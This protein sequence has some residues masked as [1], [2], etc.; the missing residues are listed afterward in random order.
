MQPDSVSIISSIRNRGLYADMKCHSTY[1]NMRSE[2]DD[3]YVLSICLMTRRV[4]D[5]VDDTRHDTCGT[6]THLQLT[7]SQAHESFFGAILEFQPILS[8]KVL[9]LI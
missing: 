4:V 2:S 6:E 7:P 1:Q 3:T 5:V 8:S 9:N